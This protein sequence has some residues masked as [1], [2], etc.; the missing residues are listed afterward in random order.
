LPVSVSAYIDLY[1]HKFGQVELIQPTH[2]AFPRANYYHVF[3]ARMETSFESA[4][5]VSPLFFVYA[6]DGAGWLCREK[7]RG[8]NL[9]R[10]GNCA[11]GKTGPEIFSPQG[12]QAVCV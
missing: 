10:G 11:K 2:Q 6:Q 12:S 7:A 4:V 1:G 8:E 5:F 3:N 9:A